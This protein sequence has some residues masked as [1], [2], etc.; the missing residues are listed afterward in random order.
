MRAKTDPDFIERHLFVDG[1]EDESESIARLI[2][3]K[4]ATFENSD[5]RIWKIN[6]EYLTTEYIYCL[7]ISPFL[8][9]SISEM[10]SNE[11]K[12]VLEL[13]LGGGS[14]D[15]FLHTHFPLM[16]ITAIEL[17]QVVAEL[18][19]K[20][21]GVKNDTSRKTLIR[22]GLSYDVI[23]LD[24]CDLDKFMSCPA[25]NL[26]NPEIVKTMKN[27]LTNTGV[28]IVNMLP[29]KD[30]EE[31]LE[32]AMKVFTDTF[33]SCLKFQLAREVNVVLACTKFDIKELN[34]MIKFYRK[35]AMKF[36]HAL[37]VPHFANSLL[38]K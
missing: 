17:E 20:W 19:E 35:R 32:S 33:P 22:D 12:K 11:G 6:H 23:F 26:R 8:V 34:V 21:F 9:S 36:A 27:L 18:A 10:K 15:M 31:Q 13:G 3:P 29:M 1:F 37:G 28:L 25:K 16:Q 14:L 7:A 24:T 5:T 38:I 30:D 2:P 4:G